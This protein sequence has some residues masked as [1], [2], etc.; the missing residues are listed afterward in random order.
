MLRLIGSR[1]WLRDGT[2]E[3][4]GWQENSLEML[5]SRLG[6]PWALNSEFSIFGEEMNKIKQR[7]LIEQI[8]KGDIESNQR[9]FSFGFLVK[10]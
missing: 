10:I 4:A 3:K 5:I 6:V 8:R 7:S 2:E 1:V 9:H